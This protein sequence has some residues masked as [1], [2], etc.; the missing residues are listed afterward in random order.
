MLS[1]APPTCVINWMLIDSS[2]RIHSLILILAHP[3]VIFIFITPMKSSFYVHS[4]YF[5]MYPC[6]FHGTIFPLCVFSVPKLIKNRYKSASALSACSRQFLPYDARFPVVHNAVLSGNFLAS[7]I[8]RHLGAYTCCQ[9]LPTLPTRCHFHL[10]HT[11]DRK[12]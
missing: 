4:S 8:Y 6:T 11:L 9:Q 12:Q 7:I 3:V 1:P 10:F 2:Q 5:L